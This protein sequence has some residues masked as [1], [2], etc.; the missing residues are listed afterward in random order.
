MK[1]VMRGAV[2]CKKACHAAVLDLR[3]GTRRNGQLDRVD[4]SNAGKGGGMEVGRLDRD[5]FVGGV[6]RRHH[7]LQ[8]RIG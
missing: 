1:A 3:A 6:D 8:R 5:R 2:Q 4:P 7:V